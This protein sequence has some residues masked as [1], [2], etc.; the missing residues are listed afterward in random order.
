MPDGWA[1]EAS[2]FHAGERQVQEKLGVRDMMESFGRKVIRDRMPE[3]HRSFYAQLPFITLGHVDGDGRV[4]ASI[5]AGRPGFISSPDA[6]SLRVA[7]VPLDGDPLE[8]GLTPGAQ[9]GFVGMD[10]SS[11]RRN[12]LNG[13]VTSVS[14][15]GFELEVGQAFGNCPQYIQKRAI[16]FVR[17]PNAPHTPPAAE[18]FDVLDEEARRTIRSADTFFVASAGQ[19]GKRGPEGGADASHRGGLPEFVGIDESDVLVIPDYS[20]NNHYNTL[21]NFVQNPRAGLLFIDFE[22]GDVL[23]LTGTVEIVWDGPEVDA[24]R[25]AERLWKLTVERGIRLRDRLPMRWQLGESSPHNALTGTW[26]Q[27][28]ATLSAEAARETWRPFRVV[29]IDDESEV[30]RSLVLEP[31]DGGASLRFEAGQHLPIRVRTAGAKPAVR[32][33]TLSSAP[34]DEHYRI[35]VKREPEGS[36]SRLLHDHIRVGDVIEARAPRGQFTFDASEKRPAVLL[37]GGVGVTPMISMLR[38]V[39]SE[40]FRTRYT[41]PTVFIHSARTTAQRAF[42]RE[43]QQLEADSRGGVSVVSFVGE[44]G[45]AEEPGRDFHA[46]GRITKDA[47]RELL[48]LDDYE[49]YLCGPGPFMQAMYDTL[50]ELGVRDARVFAE[51]FGPSSLTRRP[52]AGV[53]ASSQPPTAEEAIVEFAESK[54]EMPWT[55]KDGSLLELAESHGLTPD[56]GCRGGTCGSC[57]VKMPSG[58]VTYPGAP[59]AKPPEGHALICCGVP[60]KSKSESR[61]VLDL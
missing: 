52:D 20:G 24:F 55:P 34:S 26:D 48:A 59:H 51:A 53:V 35:S 57:A 18:R 61:V 43:A 11:R 16:A 49:F 22:R 33:Y 27:A 41:R 45:H 46:T 21:G 58:S 4:W 32:T 15:G 13:R 14:S 44:P 50:R 60:A 17:Q 10:P 9:L 1:H 28:Q 38:H 8:A 37:S 3:Q 6:R 12:R 56:Y 7:G 36:V 30:I 19:P 2:P 31:N 39:V 5:L 40:G 25:G 54:F 29:R 23:M 47:L 42:F